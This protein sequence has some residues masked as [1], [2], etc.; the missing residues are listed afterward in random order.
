M[1]TSCESYDVV[2]VGAGA[3]GL[4][5]ALTLQKLP[6]LS[7]TVLEAGDVGESFRRWPKQTRFI[8]PSFY[9]N[10]YGL[11]DLN[12]I[13]EF[14]S[15][16]VYCQT[17]HPTGQQYADY[18]NKVAQHFSVP[19]QTQ[20]Q[21]I[22]VSKNTPN[23]FCLQTPNGAIYTQYLIWATGEFQFPD[24][25]PFPGSEHCLHYAQ[26]SDWQ[27]FQSDSYVVIGGYE[28]GVD[29]SVNLVEQGHHVHLLVEQ[30]DWENTHTLDPSLTL[31]P[32]SLDR[33]QQALR[34]QALTIHF[35]VHVKAVSAPEDNRFSI[36]ASDGRV[37]QSQS[38]P[39]LA[40]GFLG[41]GGAQQIQALWEWGEDHLP[42]LSE[43]DEST[44]TPGLFL[45]GP[46]VNHESQL[47][48]FIYK[49]R[50]R[51][52]HIASLLALC[53][54]LDDSSLEIDSG[55]GNWGPFGN[56]ECCG[57]CEC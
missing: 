42:L 17:E 48:C 28:S 24:L 15:P 55:S 11:A 9:S 2:I 23:G 30:T 37:W 38:T 33:V 32:Y 36:H 25:S 19:I 50:Q 40:T 34:T 35:G 3:A 39:I 41:G 47:F 16:A 45:I 51:F 29:A 22:D 7:F 10:P 5:M 21:V 4:G 14:S 56:T 44:R 49:F 27:D 57:D 1:S 6:G 13:S 52:S 54:S 20:C 53:L 43:A 31:S 26:V 8:T 46:Q 18:L 12:A